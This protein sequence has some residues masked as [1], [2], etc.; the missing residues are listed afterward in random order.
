ML[1]YVATTNEGKLRELRELTAG[2]GLH[3]LIDEEY[4]AAAEGDTSYVENAAIKARALRES[5]VARG[6]HAAVLADDSGLEVHALQ[7]RPGVL[8]AR[9][10]GDLT[11]EARRKMLIEEIG[12]AQDRAARFVCVLHFIDERGEEI[13]S[14]AFV[15]GEITKENHGEQGFSFDPIFHYPPL[16][17]T[18]AELRLREKNAV[19]HRAIAVSKLLI[20]LN[21][22]S[23]E[24]EMG[25]ETA[26]PKA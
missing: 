22:V 25:R 18:F 23:D 3:L 11:W 19:S 15:D 17:K 4:V 2:S 13:V 9:Y 8:S 24:H 10:G 16:G 1:V 6:I 21:A 20:A 14:E 7:G 12:N 26:N 5:L